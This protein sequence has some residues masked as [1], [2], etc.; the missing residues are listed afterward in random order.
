MYKMRLT[1]NQ[2]RQ[3]GDGVSAAGAKL[4]ADLSRR[5]SDTRNIVANG[6]GLCA[7]TQNHYCTIL[8]A[9]S[10]PAAETKV[11]SKGLPLLPT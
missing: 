4:H 2:F 10:P 11:I 6:R 9:S 7:G 3:Y 8:H 1:Y 5:V